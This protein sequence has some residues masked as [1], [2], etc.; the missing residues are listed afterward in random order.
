MKDQKVMHSLRRFYAKY[1]KRWFDLALTLPGVIVISPVLIIIALLVK[2]RMGSPV[3]FR[4]QRPGINGVP[5]TIYK[6][7]TMTNERDEE[8]KLLPDKLRLTKLGRFLRSTSLDE[9][10]ELWN[11]LKGD[12]SLVGPRPLKMEYLPLY[13]AKQYQRHDVRPGITGWSQITGRNELKW[14]QRF[15]SDVW[16]VSNLSLLLDIQILLETFQKV[17]KKE[18]ISPE[19][20][21]SVLQPFQGNGPG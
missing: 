3:L 6:F 13:T 7:R 15:E 4:Q 16:Y 8:G 9:L 12:M 5:F 18:G 19:G 17:Y 2:M 14:V 11:V 21:D 20:G 10:P 1:G